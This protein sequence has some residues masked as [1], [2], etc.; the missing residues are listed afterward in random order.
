MSNILS[1]KYFLGLAAIL[2]AG[3][4]YYGVTHQSTGDAATLTESTDDVETQTVEVANPDTTSNTTES[5]ESES[6][7]DTTNTTPSDQEDDAQ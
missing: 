7:D 1:N 3:I 6:S 5:V 4:I 2:V